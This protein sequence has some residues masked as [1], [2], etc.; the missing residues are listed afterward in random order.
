VL[1]LSSILQ[2]TRAGPIFAQALPVA[3]RATTR[4]FVEYWAAARLLVQGGNPY[5]PDQLLVLQRTA[6]WRDVQPLIMWNPPWALPFV[7]PFGLL[8]FT[9]GQFLWLVLHVCLILISAQLL[10]RIYSTSGQSFRLAWLVALTFVPAGWVLIIGQITPLVPAGLAWFLYS[11]RRQNYWA[12]S[13]SLAVLSI[14]PHLL[15]LFWIVFLLWIFEKR[16][17]RLIFAAALTGLGAVLLPVLFDTRI[18]SEY[19]ALYGITEIPKPLD[20]PAPT[21]RNVIRIFFGVD[22]TWL[23]FTP[24]VMAAAWSI[25]HWERHKHQ[26]RWHEQLPLLT[27]VSVTSSI[28]VWTYDHVVLLPAILEAAAWMSRKPHSWHRYWAARVYLAINACH[29]F[30]RF[31]LA[32]EL[33]YFWLGPALLINYLIFCRERK[34]LQSS[35]PTTS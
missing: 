13:A 14:K 35:S 7:A 32:E 1:L 15:Y 17:W 6:G 20:W 2:L 24:T 5:S 25:Y 19:L 9:T 8:S 30:L 27:M 10:W 21:L 4:D 23:Q 29:F 12:M 34:N 31:W 26:W 28:F 3:E 33:W 11:E 22:Q 16:P 18:Y